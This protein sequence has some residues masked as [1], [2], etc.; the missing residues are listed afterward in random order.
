MS[1]ASL[2][3]FFS[4][5]DFDI[6]INIDIYFSTLSTLLIMQIKLKNIYQLI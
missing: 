5:G 2:V 6:S 4:K 3:S 1:I